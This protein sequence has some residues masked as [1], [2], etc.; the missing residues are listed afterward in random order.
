MYG[1]RNLNL[2]KYILKSIKQSEKLTNQ[3]FNS[4]LLLCL[5]DM[6]FKIIKSKITG[7]FQISFSVKLTDKMLIT[8]LNGKC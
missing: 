4:S 8:V 2:N 7:L 3:I 6:V 1:V 5:T